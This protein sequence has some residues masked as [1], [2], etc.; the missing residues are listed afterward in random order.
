MSSPIKRPGVLDAMI[1]AWTIATDHGFDRRYGTTTH[2]SL[3]KTIQDPARRGPQPTPERVARAA[4]ESIPVDPSSLFLDVGAG[5][6][7]VMVIAH[8]IGYRR[9]VGV[10]CDPQAVEQARQTV[11]GYVQTTAGAAREAFDLVEADV[12]SFDLPAE[13]RVVYLFNP[14][15][16]QTTERF[17]DRLEPLLRSADSTVWVVYVFPV[18]GN[19]FEASELLELQKVGKVCGFPFAVFRSHPQPSR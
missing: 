17:L 5:N 18:F 13:T 6:G 11:A 7:R 4:L 15:G 16:R 9:I 8:E 12:A 19:V 2:L 14:F 1:G 10:E 3:R